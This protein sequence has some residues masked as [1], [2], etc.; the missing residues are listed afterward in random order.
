MNSHTSMTKITYLDDEGC[1]ISIL[2]EAI[3]DRDLEIKPAATAW[4][5]DI[6]SRGWKLPAVNSLGSARRD[7]NPWEAPCTISAAL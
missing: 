4:L 3:H 2:I 7:K 6:A 5:E 1:W